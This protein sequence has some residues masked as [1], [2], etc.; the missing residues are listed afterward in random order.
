MRRR[1]GSS[2]FRDTRQLNIN[3]SARAS[4]FFPRSGNFHS[5]NVY[6]PFALCLFCSEVHIFIIYYVI[7]VVLQPYYLN[8]TFSIILFIIVIVVDLYRC[9][10]HIISLLR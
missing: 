8:I 7:I 9:R 1:T 10:A 6:T 2:R 5:R 3:R 4:G